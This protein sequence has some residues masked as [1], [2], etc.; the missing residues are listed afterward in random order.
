MLEVDRLV[1]EMD[2]AMICGLDLRART[3]GTVHLLRG[4][5]K[6]LKRATFMIIRHVYQ[7]ANNVVDWI[8][9]YVVEYSSKMIFTGT[10]PYQDFFMI[11][12][13]MIFLTVSI[14][15]LYKYF[16]FTKNKITRVKQNG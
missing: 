10:G 8:I 9:F 13:F 16:G 6:L 1:I 2:F 5:F 11:Y 12:Y 7:E 3:M 4:I 15:D 14:Q